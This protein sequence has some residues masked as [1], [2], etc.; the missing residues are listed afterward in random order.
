MVGA[1]SEIRESH[2]YNLWVLPIDNSTSPGEVLV[3]YNISRILGCQILI[4][5][6]VYRI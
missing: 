4:G 5:K 3:Y 6:N 1:T 2:L